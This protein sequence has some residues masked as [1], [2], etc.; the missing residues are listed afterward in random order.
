MGGSTRCDRELDDLVALK[1]L[2]RDLWSNK[3]SSS[4]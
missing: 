2:K 4:A 3:G 1:M